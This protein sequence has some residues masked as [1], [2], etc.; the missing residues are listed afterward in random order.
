MVTILFA[1]VSIFAFRFRSR[2]TLEL[3]LVTLQHQLAVLRRGSRSLICEPAPVSGE[4]I[5]ARVTRR[6]PYAS[7]DPAVTGSLGGRREASRKHKADED[8]EDE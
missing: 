1:V 7:R 8:D 3:K 2:A 6:Y 5:A 4:E